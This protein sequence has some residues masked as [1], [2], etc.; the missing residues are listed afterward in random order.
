MLGKLETQNSL[1]CSKYG[2]ARENPTLTN[3]VARGLASLASDVGERQI[4]ERAPRYREATGNRCG[5]TEGK[6][7]SH[8]QM[9][10]LN[11]MA[12][13]ELRQW[14]PEALRA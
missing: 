11:D 3:N 6:I 10:P 13:K 1:S 12:Q 9:R 5:E 4:P 14:L 7:R 8:H 2:D